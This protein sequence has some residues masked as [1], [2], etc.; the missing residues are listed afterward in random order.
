MYPDHD[1]KEIV[2]DFKPVHIKTELSKRQKPVTIVSNFAVRLHT[3]VLIVTTGFVSNLALTPRRWPTT[4]RKSGRAGTSILWTTLSHTPSSSASALL[5][6]EKA[7][8]LDVHIQGNLAT[9]VVAYLGKVYKLPAK[10]CVTEFGKGIKAK[11]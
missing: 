5:A 1:A 11:R 10:Y 7:K 3:L 8:E 9:E 2:G 4:R 6:S